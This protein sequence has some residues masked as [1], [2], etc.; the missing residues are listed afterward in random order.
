MNIENM[1]KDELVKLAS[2]RGIDLTPEQLK[3]VSGGGIWDDCT[4]NTKTFTC[5]YCGAVT[6]TD[7]DATSDYCH[8]C[9]EKNTFA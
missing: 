3:Q 7:S 1:S 5:A 4:G 9:G 2:E 6:E 8:V